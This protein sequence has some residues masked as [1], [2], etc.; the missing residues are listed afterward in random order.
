MKQSNTLRITLGPS[1]AAS[2]LVCL[3]S[4]G[5]AV[6]VAWL[7]VAAPVRSAMV[8]GIG[9]YAILALRMWATRSASRAIVGIDLDF[10]RTISITERSGDRIKGVLQADSY[11]TAWVTT[12]VVRPEGKRLLRSTAI[13]P[14]ML[15]VEDFRR[16]RLLLRLGHTPATG[17]DR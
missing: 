3:A 5:T 9:V 10:D 13:L 7:P 17:K 11:V 6:L 2:A 12:V 15:P 14:D 16:L 1:C 8:M 4:L